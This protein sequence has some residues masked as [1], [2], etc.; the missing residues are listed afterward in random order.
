MF[1]IAKSEK[2]TN[3]NLIYNYLKGLIVA[4][5]FSFAVIFLFAYCLKWFD[6]NR[7]AITTIVLAIKG[8]SVL[9]GAA[10]AVKGETMGL[11]KGAMFGLIYI[12]LAFTIFSFI[13]GS[14]DFNI[15]GILDGF[16]AMLVGGIVGIVKVNR[17]RDWLLFF[18]MTI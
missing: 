4:M 17:K 16:F 8:V 7:P 15:S 11:I 10:V 3:E 1:G 12:L 13:S 5:L 2:I 18:F 14:F 6:F 9:I